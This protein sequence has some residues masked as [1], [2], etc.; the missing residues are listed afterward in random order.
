MADPFLVNRCGWFWPLDDADAHPVI[1]ADCAPSIALLLPHVVGRA[2]IVQAGAN[3][4]I[5][6]VALAD[7]FR[8]VV[9][10][11][12]DPANFACLEKNLAAR[13]SLGRVGAFSA[14]FGERAGR[15]MPIEVQPRNCGAHRVSFTD[16]GAIPVI[17][18]DG[19][20]ASAGADACD[21]IW[22]DIEGGELLALKGAIDTIER[23]SPTIAVE[24][25]GLHRAFDIPDGALQAWLA[26]RGYTQVDKIG[27]DKVFRRI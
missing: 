20:L 6:P 17:T 27:R 25:K 8:S 19:A 11:E 22:L 14:A 7:H 21:C 3:V 12:P 13:D 2:L 1:L 4:G 23:F 15:C 26:E 10:C 18:I 16:K 9:T 24:D 5:Y